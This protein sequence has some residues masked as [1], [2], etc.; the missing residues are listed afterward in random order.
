M[1]T[2]IYETRRR[3]LRELVDS[4]FAGVVVDCARELDMRAPQLYRWL[5]EPEP[6]AQTRR[7]EED[8]ARAIEE[9]LSLGRGWLDEAGVPG[10]LPVAAVRLAARFLR[11][12]EETR[13]ARFTAFDFAQ[14][15]V[16][17]AEWAAELNEEISA[18]DERKFRSM[19]AK[20]VETLPKSSTI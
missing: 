11:E 8:S 9:R 1:N 19:L 2:P 5:R 15:L 16:A 13:A 18:D 4:R 3:R 6:G 17:V 10:L 20:L 12:V 14:L 7:I